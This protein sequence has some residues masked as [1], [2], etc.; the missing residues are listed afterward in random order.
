MSGRIRTLKPEWL[1]DE[2]LASL[3]DSTRLLSVALILLADD[4][5]NGRAH[6]MFIAANA[7]AYGDSPESLA[8]VSGGLRELSLAGFVKLY[9]VK[10]QRYFSIVNWEKHQKV[11]HK[12]KARV[13]G[14]EE[15]ENVEEAP[16]SGDSPETLRRTSGNPPETL[17]PDPDHDHDHDHD[18]DHSLSAA[19]P[20]QRGKPRS[21]V[22][23]VFDHWRTA[24]GKS[25]ATKLDVKRKRRI[26]WAL[27]AYGLDAVKRCIDG[28]AASRWHRGENDRGRPYDD[29]TLWLRDAEHV[30]RGIAMADQAG[31]AV[32]P[33]RGAL[34][35][36]RI[37]PEAARESQRKALE[38]FGDPEEVAR[39]G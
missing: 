25:Q 12:G 33:T 15:A 32:L 36:A 38:L 17:R 6:P 22:A 16:S 3:P 24:L 28:Y 13:P 34:P 1:E 35:P 23:E 5:G 7:W 30:E 37:D 31:P 10:G 39:V 26:E 27:R 11:S 9:T 19:E 29:L 2:R 20:P 21:D 4:Y 14:P 18:Q 8:K